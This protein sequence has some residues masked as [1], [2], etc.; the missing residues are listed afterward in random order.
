MH[1]DASLIGRQRSSLDH[2]FVVREADLSERLSDTSITF[3]ETRCS[4]PVQRKINHN[5][6]QRA[7]IVTRYELTY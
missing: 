6:I 1:G 7:A 2:Q 4:H 3:T 5:G